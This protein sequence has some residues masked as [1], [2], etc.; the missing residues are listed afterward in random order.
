[1]KNDD[2]QFVSVLAM[3]DSGPA[4]E[5][6]IVRDLIKRGVFVA[7]ILIGAPAFI[8]GVNGSWSAAYGLA[9]V[10]GNFAVAAFMVSYTAKISYA[11]MMGATLFGYIV[12]LA[13]I[14]AAVYLVRNEAWV[15]LVPLC[16]T[17]VI[18]HVGLLFWELRYVSLSL[19]F[20]G[21]KPKQTS[22]QDQV[23]PQSINN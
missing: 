22:Q 19:A 4:P 13:V 23:S 2:P 21:L 14:A 3:S 10:L 9:I 12:R 5:A 15:E 17:I 8:W 6:A 18:A 11:L 7:P 20:P 16:L 1:M